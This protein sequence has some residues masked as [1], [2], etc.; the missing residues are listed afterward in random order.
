CGK[1]PDL[2]ISPAIQRDATAYNWRRKKA[3]FARSRL[4][5]AS[6]S[7]WL[8]K[9]VEQS[10]LI[11]AII[12]ARVIPNGVVLSDFHPANKEAARA[13]LGIPQDTKLLLFAAKG[14]RRNMWKDFETARAAVALLANRLHGQNLML[15]ALG[16]KGPPERIEQAE[17]HFIPYLDDPKTVARY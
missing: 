6:P 4:Y 12:E 7:Q 14:I 13:V 11:P 8:L 10:I 16:E 17:I 5:V 15:I 1:C 2:S 9:K 3:I